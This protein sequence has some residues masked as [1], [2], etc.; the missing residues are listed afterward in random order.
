MSEAMGH[1]G[2]WVKRAVLWFGAAARRGTL[3]PYL[4]A[5]VKQVATSF[6]LVTLHSSDK[7]FFG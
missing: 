6:G 2:L 1:S 4:T 7:E 5:G 3:H